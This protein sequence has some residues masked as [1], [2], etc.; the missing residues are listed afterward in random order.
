MPSSFDYGD[1]SP[2]VDWCDNAESTAYLNS[3]SPI[4]SSTWT[5]D[6]SLT[7]LHERS[8]A[9]QTCETSK[10]PGRSLPHGRMDPAR[11][12]L[13]AHPFNQYPTTEQ[14]IKLAAAAGMTIPQWNCRLTNLRKRDRHVLDELCNDL[15]VN[16]NAPGASHHRGSLESPVSS[17]K[18]KRRYMSRPS[19]T[20]GTGSTV[21]LPDSSSDGSG[22]TA[23]RYHCTVC[24]QKSFKN[25]S[26]WKRHEAGVHHFGSTRWFCLL[27]NTLIMPGMKCVFCSDTVHDMN[28]FDQHNIQVCLAEDK[29]ARVFDRKDGLKQ[30]VVGK[31]LST[32][33]DYT[34]KGFEPPD[35]W[36]ETED[37]FS[38]NP[39]GLWCGFCKCSFETTTARMDHVAQH[40]KN[41]FQISKWVSRQD[42]SKIM[43][44]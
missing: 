13:H 14:K 24:P 40:F 6:S 44:A 10:E 32:A 1:L 3:T 23:N 26:S 19:P 29:S 4:L 18:G 28:H 36:S 25:P 12:W 11:R 22:D 34:K 30:H 17:R 39:D 31:H 27:N 9:S 20:I 7:S 33:N 15:D 37:G 42:S 41:G 21:Q 43:F 8:P 2:L 35:A 5:D 38:P 16:V